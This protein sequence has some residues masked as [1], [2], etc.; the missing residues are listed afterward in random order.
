MPVKTLRQG[1]VCTVMALLLAAPVGAE[2]S[3][4]NDPLEG[5]NR[6]MFGFNEQVDRFALKPM[7]QG[8][9]YVM[10]DMAE[11]GV[12]N[13][14]GNLGDI[15]SAVNNLLQG[16]VDDALTSVSRVVFNSTFGLAGFIDVATPMGIEEKREDFGQTLG[17]WGVGSGPYLVLPLFGPSS[18]RD[19]IGLVP[20]MAIDPVG[21]VDHVP[22]RNSLY[23][24]RMIDTRVALLK[25]E[26][27]ISGD[28]YIFVRDAYLQRR[29]YLINDG[30]V[31]VN[32]DESDF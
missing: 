11:R 18:V 10:P 14:F 24:L 25:A 5:F 9:H 30:E 27:I 1:T 28:K 22:T 31:Q 13:F 8:Y 26:Q 21:E 12:S 7:A 20:D 17:S 15:R 2:T 19:G 6:A 29:E 4:R 32:Y 3:T 23:G 16:K